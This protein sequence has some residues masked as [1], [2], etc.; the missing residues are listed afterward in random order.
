MVYVFRLISAEVDDFVRDIAIGAGQSFHDLH[1]GIQQS[2]Q[3]DPSQLA[4]FFI[5]DEDWLRTAELTLL[6][7]SESGERKGLTMQDSIL[8]ETLAGKGDKLQYL[9]DYFSD[10]AFFMELVEEN[11]SGDD[12][13]PPAVIREQGHPPPQIIID[14]APDDLEEFND[15]DFDFDGEEG[16][17]FFDPEDLDNL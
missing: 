7:M 17:E 11:G 6:D 9:Y 5:C 13:A 14:H 16:D 3:Y 2:L 15:S 8:G 1:L 4:S 12:M 10:R